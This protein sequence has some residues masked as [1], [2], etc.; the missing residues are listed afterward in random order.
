LR[1][2]GLPWLRCVNGDS[3]SLP[4]AAMELLCGGTTGRVTLEQQNCATDSHWPRR[5]RSCFSPRRRTGQTLDCAS[6]HSETRQDSHAWTST[7][8]SSTSPLTHFRKILVTHENAGILHKL[9]PK[10]SHT[11]GKSNTQRSVDECRCRPSS[12][13]TRAQ[14]TGTYPRWQSKAGRGHTQ[15]PRKGTEDWLTSS[16]DPPRATAS[17][18]PWQLPPSPRR[19]SQKWPGFGRKSA[20][21]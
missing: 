3:T 14:A 13:V 5:R 17:R 20:R 12:L 11:L 19:H 15:P 18:R 2:N 1:P 21:N 9:E 4:S 16:N 6:A 10:P 8:T 7:G